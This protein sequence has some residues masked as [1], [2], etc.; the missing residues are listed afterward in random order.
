MKLSVCVVILLAVLALAPSLRT[1][2]AG[3]QPSGEERKPVATRTDVYCAGY[4]SESSS[5]PDL[6]IVGAERENLKHSYEQGDI[7]FLDKGREHGVRPGQTY[8][9]IRPI[10]KM[11]HPFTGKKI[12]TYVHEV[13]MVRVLQVNDRTSTAEVT[14]SCDPVE[15]GDY[16]RVYEERVAPAPRPAQPL[17]LHGESSG[18]ISGQ[19]IGARHNREYLAANDIV[20]LDLGER[21]GVKEGD[22]FTVYHKISSD[23]ENIAKYPNDKIYNKRSDSYQ[24]DHYRGGEFSNQSL[25]KERQ[26]VLDDRPSIPRK[27]LGEVVILRVE[28]GTA[29]G[30]VTRT[31]G[32]VNVGDKVERSN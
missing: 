3:Q 26:K 7:V 30:L 5:W 22:Y 29:T 31:A 18:D 19:I 12:G 24:S 16:L 9:I 27:V 23:W 15:L 11:K 6:H 20:Y 21:Q 13:G 8:Y 28:K 1:S 2:R 14:V 17:P 32:V 25:A 4:I 10:D